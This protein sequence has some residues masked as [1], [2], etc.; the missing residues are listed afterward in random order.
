RTA[1]RRT[2]A[3]AAEE[4]WPPPAG[5]A[6]EPSRSRPGQARGGGGHGPLVRLRRGGDQLVAGWSRR[7][8]SE[9]HGISTSTQNLPFMSKQTHPASKSP[10]KSM[11]RLMNGLPQIRQIETSAVSCPSHLVGIVR[12][13]ERRDVATG[14]ALRF[15]PAA[16]LGHPTAAGGAHGL[17]PRESQP[18]NLGEA[19]EAP[20]VDE[21]VVL[22]EARLGRHGRRGVGHD[23][24]HVV[25]AHRPAEVEHG[26]ARVGVVD[27]LAV[28]E[29]E[30]LPG[31]D[32]PD[33]GDV[34]LLA[35]ARRA[36]LPGRDG[37]GVREA[38][39][40][41]HAA[42][43]VG[44]PLPAGDGREVD[45][46]QGPVGRG[47]GRVRGLAPPVRAHLFPGS[48]SFEIVSIWPVCGRFN[49]TARCRDVFYGVPTC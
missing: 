49:S 36:R 12:R 7:G 30:P 37:V 21:E 18:V 28:G 3:A 8:V 5:T 44:Y 23:L 15:P 6:A 13:L 35:A 9:E 45:R 48:L 2:D 42:L 40:P 34:V 22:A 32:A 19:E 41:P 11:R 24:E 26:A 46:V 29:D 17:A 33:E 1:R 20:P 14:S 38:E 27:L 31:R 39:P 43:R 4:A 47:T 16:A 25:A 10:M